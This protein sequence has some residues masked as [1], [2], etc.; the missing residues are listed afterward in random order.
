MTL[1]DANDISVTLGGRQV[2]V[3]VSIAL[4][5]GEIVGLIGPNG[6]GKTTLL[7]V[8][9]NLQQVDRGDVR[10]GGRSLTELGAREIARRAAYLAQNV[11]LHWPLTVRRLTALGRLPR[12]GPWQRP[13]LL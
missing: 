12:L 11:P 8:L 3:S 6:A 1:L 9:A 13:S 5:E 2:L 7:R 4:G 10:F